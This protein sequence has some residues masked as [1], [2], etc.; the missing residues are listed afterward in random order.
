MKYL[1][2]TNICV[3]LLN[4]NDLLEKKVRR[5]GVHSI[6]ITH[7]VLSELYYGAYNSSRVRDNLKRIDEFREN[8][9]ILSE[10]VESARQFGKI[11]AELK[12]NGSLI[13]DFDILIASIAVANS[14]AVVTNNENHFSRIK[15]L[16]VKNWLK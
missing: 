8:I 1:L 5:I 12:S 9:S 7:T 11:K 16:K 2:D 4:G 6:G 10:N 14:Y 13:D 3:Y 15:G